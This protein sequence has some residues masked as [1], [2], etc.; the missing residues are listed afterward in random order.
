MRRM[1]EWHIIDRGRDYE[2]IRFDDGG[3]VEVAT[4]TTRE[5]AYLAYECDRARVLRD[6]Q[7]IEVKALEYRTS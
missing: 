2:V 6:A 1:V 4:P 7:A 3:V 5:E